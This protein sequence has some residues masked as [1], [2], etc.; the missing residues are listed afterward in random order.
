M[1]L[2]DCFSSRRGTI[3][4]VY[5]PKP[6]VFFAK[7]FFDKGSSDYLTGVGAT[8]SEAIGAARFERNRLAS[9]R[10]ACAWVFPFALVAAY[11]FMA[12]LGGV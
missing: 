9:L 6:G 8:V 3:L 7:L 4:D 10:P 11:A 12:R 2:P 1:K 5:E